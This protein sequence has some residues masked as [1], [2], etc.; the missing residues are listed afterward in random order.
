MKICTVVG[1]RPQFIK[2]AVVSAAIRSQLGMDEFL[3]HTGQHYDENMSDVFFEELDIPRPKHNLGIGGGGH[4]Q[5]TGR[6][7]IEMER[8]L[9]EERPDWV[10]VYGDTNSTLAGALAAAKLHIPIAHVEAGLRS[11][12]R[13]MPEEVNRVLTDHVS[14]EL[15]APTE[16]AVENLLKEGFERSQ[17]LKVGDV[18][19]DA[20]LHFGEKAKGQ[21]ELL[22]KLDVK[23]GEFVLA[24]V[25]RASNTDDPN[26]L[27]AIY[28]GLQELSTELP[29]VW[30]V[31]PRTRGAFER[32]GLSGETAGAVRFTEPLSYLEMV[33]LE[34]QCRMVATDSGGVQ[35]EA[36]FFGKPCAVFRAETEWTEL[37]DLG[38]TRLLEPSESAAV[39]AGL[40]DML[41]QPEPTP[42]ATLPFGAGDA[43]QQIAQRLCRAA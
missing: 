37:V 27:H 26:R 43:S 21:T 5:Q 38:W 33:T 28:Q 14:T 3:V 9:V 12:N 1:A 30:P 20:A 24:T 4:G 7:L 17:I 2:A 39:Q 42:V 15:F 31:H 41:A 10:L 22:T 29:V 18:M 36:Y 23:P 19:F 8:V 40:A 13:E 35:K 16:T 25:H 32:A 11:F 6:M 34:S